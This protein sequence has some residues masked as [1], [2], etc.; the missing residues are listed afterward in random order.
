MPQE[1]PSFQDAKKIRIAEDLA[2]ISLERNKL[3]KRIQ[4]LEFKEAVCT[5]ES[6][7]L[8]IGE[9]SM[10]T[11]DR[12]MIPCSDGKFVLLRYNSGPE[13]IKYDTNQLPP[14][15]GYDVTP[16]A[17]NLFRFLTD[18]EDKPTSLQIYDTKAFAPGTSSIYN[19]PLGKEIPLDD[20]SIGEAIENGLP[21]KEFVSM[22][23]SLEIPKT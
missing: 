12:K 18:K 20:Q 23:K 7:T 1:T 14:G 15:Y 22:M 2:S 21:L 19:H 13:A 9:G 16:S 10:R 5:F 11:L 6:V 8:A 17:S 4:I 3:D